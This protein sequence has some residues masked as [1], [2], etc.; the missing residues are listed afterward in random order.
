MA[1]AGATDA[2]VWFQKQ[3]TQP[4]AAFAPQRNLSA[5][6]PIN[7]TELASIGIVR[8]FPVSGM[9]NVWGRY[10]VRS[11]T[12]TDVTTQRGKTGAGTIWQFDSV[13]MIF[14]D[15][16]TNSQLTWTDTNAN[17]VFDRG[18]PGE[19]IALTRVRAEAQRL[20]VGAPGRERRFA[21][22]HVQR[23]QPDGRRLHQ[24]RPRLDGR[25]RRRL[26]ERDRLARRPPGR[27]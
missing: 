26:Q 24:P 18:E 8:T 5:T 27:R 25:Q 23:G 7:D 12:V 9:G 15:R 3:P 22:L 19:V 17:G 16:D 21:E 10:E 14:V 11:P 4:V 2:L 13:G 1:R 20:V 6:P